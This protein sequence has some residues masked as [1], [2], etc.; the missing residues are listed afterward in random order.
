[1][2][3]M[4]PVVLAAVM[5]GLVQHRDAI[6]QEED[7]RTE[8]AIP[9][10]LQELPPYDLS[11]VL[12]SH[13]GFIFFSIDGCPACRRALPRFQA[14]EQ[15]AED[16]CISSDVLDF[17]YIN[18]SQARPEPADF[19]REDIEYVPTVIEVQRGTEVGRYV[20]AG[21]DFDQLETRIQWLIDW[22]QR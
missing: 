20:G 12:D 5:G 2:K 8:T 13:Y 1:M 18:L 21:E 3:K 10:A 11:D 19:I 16:A 17:E 15:R 4:A 14:L 7:P 22:Y 6:P 9:H